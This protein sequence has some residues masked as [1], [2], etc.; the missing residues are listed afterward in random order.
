MSIKAAGER[1]RITLKSLE[2]LTYLCTDTTRLLDL[3]TQLKDLLQKFRADLPQEEQ[4]IV[5][6]SIVS[7]AIGIKRKY[8]RIKPKLSRCSKLPKTKPKGRRKADSKFRNRVGTRADRLGIIYVPF[9]L[10]YTGKTRFDSHKQSMN[11]EESSK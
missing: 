4:L 7:R 6:P 11:R 3:D 8:A 1:T 5:R 9:H 2:S 10:L